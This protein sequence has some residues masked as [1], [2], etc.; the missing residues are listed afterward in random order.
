MAEQILRLA[1]EIDLT[2]IAALARW[3][4]LNSYADSGVSTGVARFV[5]HAFDPLLLGQSLRRE[6]MWI[7]E[8]GEHLQAWAELDSAAS[9]DN[10][11]LTRLYVAPPCCGRGLGARLLQH[12]RSTHRQ[13]AFWL[14][15]WE[16]NVGA[17]RFY[18]REGARLLGETWFELDGQ[19]HRNE[20]LGWPALATQ[21]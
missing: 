12:L 16:G 17:L 18:R 20:V 4:W 8:V 9:P 14:S 1:Q 10:I 19:R 11:E 3:V 13:R 15:A 21:E 2:R 6:P 5:E 7:I